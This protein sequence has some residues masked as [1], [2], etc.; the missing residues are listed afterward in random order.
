M[1]WNQFANDQDRAETL[2][3]LLLGAACASGPLDDVHLAVVNGQVAKALGVSE[4]PPALQRRATTFDAA[5]FDVAAACARLGLVHW[6]DRL[7]LVRT[8]VLVARAEGPLTRDARLYALQV[9][10]LLALPL[11][12]VMGVVGLPHRPITAPRPRPQVHARV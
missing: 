1:R 8:V 3:D 12:D 2:C 4:L 10:A 7:A 5:R 6:R 9:A 11:P